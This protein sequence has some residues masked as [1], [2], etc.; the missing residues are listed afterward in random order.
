MSITFFSSFIAALVTLL[1]VT[2]AEL[3]QGVYRVSDFQ[4]KMLRTS[5]GPQGV[6]DDYPGGYNETYGYP[7]GIGGLI[8][9]GPFAYENGPD[10]WS[11]D[12]PWGAYG[13]IFAGGQFDRETRECTAVP[14]DS[15]FAGSKDVVPGAFN[16]G[17]DICGLTC[18]LD[19]VKNTGVD[20]CHAGNIGGDSLSNSPMSCF[21]IGNMLKAKGAGVC[22]YNCTAFYADDPAV[23]CT[24]DN[25]GGCNIYCDSRTF[26]A[27][28]SAMV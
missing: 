12:N 17:L 15:P 2:A 4:Q 6:S 7:D 16:Q 3:P 24:A 27:T 10:V 18:N 22:A 26:P 19:D 21:D 25:V 9:E 23:P 28:P 5:S 20:P 13:M 8:V 14:D 11:D 1:S